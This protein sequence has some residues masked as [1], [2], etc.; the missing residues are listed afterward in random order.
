MMLLP[1]RVAIR[2]TPDRSFR[3]FHPLTPPRTDWSP[4]PDRQIR[5][6]TLSPPDAE[7]SARVKRRA[8]VDR[9][10]RSRT[11]LATSI[12]NDGTFSWIRPLASTPTMSTASTVPMIPPR[13][14]DRLVPPS[15]TAVTTDSSRPSPPFTDAPPTWD[16]RMRPASATQLL[17]SRKAM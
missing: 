6:A 3:C 15:T 5:E 16:R 4:C 9:R 2:A 17:E 14:P 7:L 10:P 12:Q 11:P 13:P 8:L 1:R